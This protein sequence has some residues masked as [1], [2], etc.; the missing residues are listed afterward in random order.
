MSVPKT[1]SGK[2][3][4]SSQATL[5]WAEFLYSE[6]CREGRP[7]LPKTAKVKKILKASN[8]DKVRSI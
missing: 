3:I 6:Y 7:Q 2:P 5:E 1:E 4:K 8:H